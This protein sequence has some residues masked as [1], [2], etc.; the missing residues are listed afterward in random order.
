METIKK[1]F[2]ITELARH[3]NISVS[4]AHHVVHGKRKGKKYRAKIEAFLKKYNAAI[5]ELK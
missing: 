4:Y 5:S 2:N 3:L 1:P